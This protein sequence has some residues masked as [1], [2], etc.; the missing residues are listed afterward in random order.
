MVAKLIVSYSYKIIWFY[1]FCHE[2]VR[3]K[4]NLN[5]FDVLCASFV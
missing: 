3:I 2:T 5:V 4:C 1:R